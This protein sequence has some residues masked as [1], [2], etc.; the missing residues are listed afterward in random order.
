MEIFSDLIEKEKGK[1]EKSLF[2][3][4]NI[5]EMISFLEKQENSIIIS[6]DLIDIFDYVSFYKNQKLVSLR[7]LL[8][9]AN[10]FTG[11]I[12]KLLDEIYIYYN[13]K[14][15]VTTKTISRKLIY[16]DEIR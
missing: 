16:F 4:L 10:L 13:L 2:K 9:D 14:T 12:Q 3:D 1:F 11:E 7:F 6:K 8:N 5:I 15:I